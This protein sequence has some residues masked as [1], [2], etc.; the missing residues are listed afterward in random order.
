VRETL[1]PR[2]GKAHRL[3]WEGDKNLTPPSG[4]LGAAFLPD[5]ELNQIGP[6][7]DDISL[8]WLRPGTSTLDA[9]NL[10]ES[11]ASAAGIGQILYG[12]SLETMFDAPGQSV[13]SV[14]S[15]MMAI[16]NM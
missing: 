3:P 16:R 1:A 2:N 10:L 8:L 12:P 7:E 11:N 9:V 6:T 4:V 13:S 5:S 14:L 15:V